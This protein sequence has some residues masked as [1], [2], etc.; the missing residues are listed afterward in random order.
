MSR[1][2]HATSVA[3][4]NPMKRWWI[5]LCAAMVLAG[6]ASPAHAIGPIFD[7]DPAYFWF[8]A[9]ATYD[10]QPIGTPLL[11]V[12]T[13]SAF[14]PPV[15]FLNATM[16]AT[17][18]TFYIQGLTSQGTTS[19][20][21]FHTTYY[22]GGTFEMYA[23]NSPDA[24][25]APNPP[26]AQVPSTFLDEGAPLL[27]GVFTSFVVN[28]NDVTT[29]QVGNIEGNIQ[30]TGGSLLTY[31]NG[32]NSE[33]CP[34]LFTGGSTWRTNPGVGIPGYIFRHDG[35]I[36]LQCPTPTAKSTWGKLKQLY[37]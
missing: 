33:P 34:G 35:K 28:T 12:G 24:V 21:G 1:R 32:P 4:E 16:P 5:T 27:T 36:D 6:A 23:D 2:T 9:P 13:I 11:A 19:A 10:N 29:F 7:W 37:R 3:M 17:E 22:S 14:G 8:G 20:L 30:W 15:D 31:L 18:Y 25:F 26:N